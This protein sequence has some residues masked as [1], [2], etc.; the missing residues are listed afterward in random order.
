MTSMMNERG[1]ITKSRE[2]M[3][4]K[5]LSVFGAHVVCNASPDPRC[6]IEYPNLNRQQA[7]GEITNALLNAGLVPLIPLAPANRA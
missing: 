3:I 7:E 6:W 5:V 2:S 1:T 4:D